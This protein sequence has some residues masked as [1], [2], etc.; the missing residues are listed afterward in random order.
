MGE[1]EDSQAELNDLSGG[2][3]ADRGGAESTWAKIKLAA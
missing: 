3:D 2:Q 1:A